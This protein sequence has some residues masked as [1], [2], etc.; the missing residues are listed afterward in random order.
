MVRTQLYLPEKLYKGLKAQA[1][2]KGMTFAGY[3]RVYLEKEVLEEKGK[4]K[5]LYQK[6]PF[7]KKAGS[8]KLGKNATDNDEIDK[9]IYDL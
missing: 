5:S 1:K 8:L 6:Y 2:E 3:V 9:A 7:L 4:E